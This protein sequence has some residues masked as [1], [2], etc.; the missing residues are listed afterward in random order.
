MGRECDSESEGAIRGGS[1]TVRGG[2]NT[3][4][5]CDGEGV[6]EQHQTFQL[7]SPANLEISNSTGE[8][9]WRFYLKPG[10]IHFSEQ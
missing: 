1:V 6:R 2:S 3:G 4:R 8:N 5:E 10:D 7:E 9:P